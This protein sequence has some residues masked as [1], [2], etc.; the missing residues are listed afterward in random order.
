[1]FVSPEQEGPSRRYFE[2]IKSGYEQQFQCLLE[3]H[4]FDSKTFDR[5]DC[6][7]FGKS[8][9]SRRGRTPSL[10]P[11]GH[12]AILS[13]LAE[14]QGDLIYLKNID[15]ILPDRLRGPTIIWKKALGGL[16]VEIQKRIYEYVGRLTEGSKDAGLLETVIDFARKRLL[17]PEPQAFKQSTVERKGVTF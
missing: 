6:R 10:Q 5:Y 8:A 15:N 9:L 4:F 12:G 3:S 13:N 17:I 16:L 7:G 2:K 14:V 11:G 1:M